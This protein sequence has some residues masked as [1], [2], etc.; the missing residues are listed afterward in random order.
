[1]SVLTSRRLWTFVIAQVVSIIT[2][3]IGHFVV[4]PFALELAKL[5][6][7][8]V[9]GVASI[10]IIAYTVDDITSNVAAIKAGSHPDYPAKP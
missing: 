4:D 9:E 1:M 3:A 7:G 5:I 6:I 10:L 8:L 2:L